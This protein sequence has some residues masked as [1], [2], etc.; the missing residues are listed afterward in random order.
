MILLT[1]STGLEGSTPA[2]FYKPSHHRGVDGTTKDL[3]SL[4]FQPRPTVSQVFGYVNK[5]PCPSLGRE[6]SILGAGTLLAFHDLPV[7]TIT[8]GDRLVGFVARFHLL[9][10]LLDI[11]PKDLHRWVLSPVGKIASKKVPVVSQQHE[12]IEVF[13]VMK[14][15]GFGVALVE[16]GRFFG[17]ITLE[18][19]L[20]WIEPQNILNDIPLS[21]QA[22][23]A[24]PETPLLDALRLMFK[25]R[26]RRL[27]V[28]EKP[29]AVSDREI[30]RYLFSPYGVEQLKSSPESTL[31]TP[32]REVGAVDALSA[33]APLSISQAANLVLSSPARLVLVNEYVVT[34]WDV[35]SAYF[36]RT[37]NEKTGLNE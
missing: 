15:T 18:D 37:L 6:Q 14:K 8:E 10:K 36:E 21:S 34:P 27:L 1:Y 9:R 29:A 31:S 4:N 11:K 20:V 33:N 30:I 28:K 32:I 5:R 3:S 7:L 25:L 12:L 24:P 16:K 13:R 23:A 26:I 35:V 2:I 19:F 17:L 22:V